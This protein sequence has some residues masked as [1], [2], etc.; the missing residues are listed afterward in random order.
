MAGNTTTV[1]RHLEPAWSKVCDEQPRSALCM[2]TSWKRRGPGRIHRLVHC[3]RVFKIILHNINTMKK[4]GNGRIARGMN[5]PS[6]SPC[7]ASL[8]VPSYSLR[9]RPG[10]EAMWN[11]CLKTTT[12]RLTQDRR[13][14]H[15]EKPIEDK[16]LRSNEHDC[17][18]RSLGVGSVGDRAQGTGHRAQLSKPACSARYSMA[19]SSR[20]LRLLSSGQKAHSALER[21]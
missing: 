21:P 12:Q 11:H 1:R 4:S 6:T 8:S 7:A 16:L 2:I 17:D 3:S 20:G 13:K 19:L 9:I 18:E 5:L 10:Y 14:R 15:R